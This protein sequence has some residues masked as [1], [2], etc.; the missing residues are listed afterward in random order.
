VPSPVTLLTVAV[1]AFIATRL[2]GAVGL[3]GRP[4]VRRHLATI[5]RGVRARHVVLAVP[6]LVAVATSASLLIEVP[7]LDWGWWTALGGEGNP[8]VGSTERTEGTPLAWAIPLLFL[9]LLIP[10]LPL[11]AEREEQIFRAGA[12]HWS[13]GRRFV[14]SLE[15]GL[16]HAVIGIPI[17]VALALTVGGWY[18]TACYLRAY[19]RTGRPEFA[20]LESTR[21]HLAYNAVIVAIVLPTLL[22]L[23]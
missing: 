19:R 22:V 16:V 7:G 10:V 1:L 9:L 8:V 12:E 13:R 17:G 6:V 5:V 2:L 15:F 23:A 18:F 20:L 11:F 14:R 4:E 3:I 21:A